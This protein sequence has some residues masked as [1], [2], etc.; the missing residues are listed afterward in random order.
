MREEIRSERQEKLLDQDAYM[1][2]LFEEG[3][4]LFWSLD[5]KL[6]DEFLLLKNEIAIKKIKGPQ[7]IQLYMNLANGMLKTR[8][9]L[10]LGD[11]TKL[12]LMVK[13]YKQELQVLGAS[14][15]I[16][17][18]IEAE[19]L[20]RFREDK[21]ADYKSVM[22]DAYVDIAFLNEMYSQA[23][24]EQG[25]EAAKEIAEM[26]GLSSVDD[27][28]KMSIYEQNTKSALENG[29]IESME[30]LVSHPLNFKQLVKPN[31]A[32]TL[33]DLAKDV[34]EKRGLDS[35][36]YSSTQNMLS[37]Q[38]MSRLRHAFVS[39]KYAIGIAAVNQTNHSLNQRQLIYVNTENFDN[40]P[41]ED[42]PW[43]GD[44]KI[45]FKQYNKVRIGKKEFPTLSMIKNAA[46]EYISDLIGQ[47]IDGYVD[48]AKGPWIMELGA[49]PNVASTYLFLVK[50][51]VPIKSVV[52]F[53]NQPI[54]RDYLN[55]IENAGYSWLFIDDMFSETLKSYGNPSTKNVSEIPSEKSL[56]D[57]IGK[58][59]KDLT[60][61]Q[62]EQQ[63][64]ILGEFVKYAKLA[65]HM[66]M[67]TQG[68]NFD[69]SNFNDPYLVFKKMVQYE[70]AQQTLIS[71]YD[72]STRSS[73]PAVE[74]IVKNSFLKTLAST[75]SDVRNAYAE[76]LK[77]DRSNVRNVVEPILRD[78]V[79]VPDREFVKIAQKVV[80]D[81][82]DWAVQ[83]DRGFNDYVGKI[84]MGENNS[85]ER[86]AEFVESV[87]KNKKHPLYGNHVINLLTH[88]T[89]DNGVNNLS[90]ANRDNKVYD[91]NQIIYAFSEIRDYLKGKDQEDL[92]KRIVLT[93][94]LQSGLS[95]S[96]I[97]FTSLLPYED[98]KEM[99]NKSLS[100]LNQLPN[101]QSYRDLGVFYRNNW[102]NDDVVSQSIA[103][104]IS[105][106]NKY[107]YIEY[108]Y[109]PAMAWLP[110]SLKS[111]VAEGKI[112]QVMSVSSLSQDANSEFISYSWERPM[113]DFLT[114]KEMELPYKERNALWKS[115]KLEMRKR[116]NYSYM[117][118]GLFRKVYNGTEPLSYTYKSKGEIRTNYVYKMVNA[119]GD[120]FRANEFYDVA[121]PSV[122]D[123]G[124]LKIAKEITDDVIGS[125]LLGKDFKK[126]VKKPVEALEKK[127]E[128]IRFRS[129]FGDVIELSDANFEPT[130]ESYE[131]ST[132]SKKVIKP[133]GRP[134]IKNKNNKNCG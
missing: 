122:I 92:Y 32:D 53:M 118:K 102:N 7:E 28:A 101:L 30:A 129:E 2:E 39:G 105:Y 74:A 68:S 70:K 80:T 5:K 97:S 50:L 109:N 59:A 64:F 123:N 18:K 29:Y 38:F 58:K 111:A 8:K 107:G 19:A 71:S 116:G 3:A 124:F 99:Y 104:L 14:E 41:E 11:K 119:W 36:D 108:Q 67:V 33:K 95:S 120:S 110:E 79:D 46:G 21:K 56:G 13:L 85:P 132:E 22:E 66:F 26:D 90:L 87:K 106:T 134:A 25:F 44:G 55:K 37:R 48:I 113:S 1:K 84:L 96:K 88:T 57:M 45:K 60:P 63:A 81:L 10:R 75:I 114:K 86:V 89:A 15:E 131:E 34:V 65:S 73:V 77:S 82:F 24:T 91:Q 31:S 72:P 112:P 117:N 125:V 47:F 52:Y 51:G 27:F 121:K 98:F 78:F 128:T 17:N 127:S 6:I 61:Q 35:F 49:N 100:K 115:K 42:K 12:T 83:T 9:D 40:I 43:L 130:P 76:I 103:R 54:I 23:L 126:E 62:K 4:K 69:T 93:S 133:K 20:A 16:V 94:V